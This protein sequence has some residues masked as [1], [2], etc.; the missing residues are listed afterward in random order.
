MPVEF[1]PEALL[2]DLDGVRCR[3]RV[4][5][6]PHGIGNPG[7]GLDV[8]EP[9]GRVFRNIGLRERGPLGWSRSLGIKEFGLVHVHFSCVFLLESA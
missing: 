3:V 7:F 4:V 6:K 2:R 9:E 5:G 1:A 8:F